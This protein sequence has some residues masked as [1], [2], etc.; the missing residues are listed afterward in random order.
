MSSFQILLAD[1]II[2]DGSDLDFKKSQIKP[3]IKFDRMPKEN[4]TI[5]MVDP[6]APSKENPT[7]KHWLHL[8]IINNNDKIMDYELPSP[9]EGSG[10]HRYIFYLLAQ[11]DKLNKNNLKSLDTDKRNNFQLDDFIK[12][13]NLTI[14]DSVHFITKR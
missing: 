3:K 4:F 7:K 14:V 6:D 9:P 12:N 1:E 10:H 2:N 5:L 11:K 13:N 8:L